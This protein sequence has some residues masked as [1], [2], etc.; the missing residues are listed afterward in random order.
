MTDVANP[1]KYNE[2]QQTRDKPK[3]ENNNQVVLPEQVWNL[4]TQV[5]QQ[6]V[7]QG[8]IQAGRNLAHQEVKE[9][10]HEFH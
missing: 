5:Q 2:K 9:R 6:Q 10:N 1:I 7:I 4:L 8:L 3:R